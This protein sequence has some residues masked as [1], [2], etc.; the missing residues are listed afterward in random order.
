MEKSTVYLAGVPSSLSQEI[1]DRYHFDVG[2]LPVRY[3]GLPLVTKRLTSTDYRSLLEQIKKKIGSWTAR[4]L[5]YAGRL[6]LITSVLWSTCNFWLSAFRLPRGCIKEIEKLCSAFL[7]SGPDLNPHKAKLS[8]VDVCKPKQE[9]GLGL[10]PLKEINDVCCLKLIWRLVSH[11]NSLWVQWIEKY[12]LKADTFWSVKATTNR[13]SW[14]WSKL[15]KYRDVAKEFCKVEVRNGHR[16]SFW[17]EKA[18]NSG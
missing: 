16:T 13:G 6:S 18:I 1:K 15:I 8:W 11:A 14:M 5:S 17:Y 9:G 4:Y 2:H 10:R 7:W 12:L 3:L